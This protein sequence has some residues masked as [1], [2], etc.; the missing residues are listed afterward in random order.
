MHQPDKRHHIS[1][2]EFQTINWLA[3]Y[4]KVNQCINT[5]T[6][7]FVNNA[8]PYYLND[9]YDYAAPCR[10]TFM[11]T[12]LTHSL[13]HSLTHPPT[14]SRTHSLTH[15]LLM[16][17]LLFLTFCGYIMFWL[18]CFFFVKKVSY[19]RNGDYKKQF[20]WTNKLNKDLLDCHFK[21]R[22]DP[23]KGYLKKM[24]NL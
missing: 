12:P 1:T 13:T 16:I 15:L 8:F 17:W 20:H 3:A 5:I 22:K 18:I 14:H 6:F 7:K 19:R 2:K 21:A 4:A 11:I 9:V 24:K 23:S 10:M